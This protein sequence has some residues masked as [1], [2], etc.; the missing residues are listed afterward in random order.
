VAGDQLGYLPL[1]L[2]LAHAHV[3]MQLQRTRDGRRPVPARPLRGNRQA[4][5][6]WGSMIEQATRLNPGSACTFVVNETNDLG[7]SRTRP[8]TFVTKSNGR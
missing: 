7:G 1:Q 8:S 3:S 4:R 2:I 6:D 5:N